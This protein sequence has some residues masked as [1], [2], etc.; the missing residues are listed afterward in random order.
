MQAYTSHFA[1]V[2][3]Q[4]W[5]GFA[6]QFA[7][8]ILDY[9]RRAP[10]SQQNQTLL[11][12]CCGTGQ[13]AT[14]FLE[15]GYHV[16]GIDSSEGML[17]HAAANNTT[18]VQTGQ[19]RFIQADATAF[20]LDTQVELAVSTFDALN[21]LEDEAAL[22][23][24]FGCVFAALREGGVFIFDLNTRAGLRQWNSISVEDTEDALIVNRGFYDEQANRA[25]VRISG[26]LRSA[27]G[28]YERFEEMAY[29]TAFDLSMVRGDLL[30][31]GW[32]EVYFARGQDLATPVAE[33]ENERRICVV[34][35]K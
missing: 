26:F 14:Y 24:C 31:A 29:E 3:N 27:D 20:I 11:D 32:H 34:A 5:A 10:I 1:N 17:Q 7:P 2:Y 15:Q 16:I 30:Q 22:R 13:L 33:P 6:I 19:A 35:R 25:A 21:H 28:S 23:R 12:V 18:Y 8:R 4:K 9:Y